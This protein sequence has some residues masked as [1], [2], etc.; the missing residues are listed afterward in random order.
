MNID[1]LKVKKYFWSLFGVIGV[2]C[3]WAGIWDGIGTLPYLEN[4]LISLAFGLIILISSGLIFKELGGE[5]SEM[6][7]SVY[8]AVS[9]VYNH[10]RKHEFHLLYYDK[11]KKKHITF[12]GDQLKNI[13]KSF[14]VLHHPKK[15]IF[16][17]IDRV[18]EIKHHGKS[19]WK[20]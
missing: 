7:R 17:P 1:R 6:E 14:L 5:M 20:S 11:I 4:P 15:E 2:V 18:K 10:K 8:K 19:H 12:R 3:F 16:V 9:N 13:E